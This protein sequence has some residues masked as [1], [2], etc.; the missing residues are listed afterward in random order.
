MVLPR[1]IQSTVKTCEIILFPAKL[2]E[3]FPSFAADAY[4]GMHIS[5][6]NKIIASI[7]F[8]DTIEMEEVESV[9]LVSAIA[10]FAAGLAE[11]VFHTDVICGVPF[12]EKFPSL[13]VQFLKPAI[14]DPAAFA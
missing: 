5:R 1:K 13:K 10:V 7:S 14:S 8:V 3:D 11:D 9:D 2:P 6:G 12:E 4:D